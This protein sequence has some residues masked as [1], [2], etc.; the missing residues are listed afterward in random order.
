MGGGGIPVENLAP[1]MVLSESVYSEDGRLLL[2]KQG[3]TISEVLKRGLLKRGITRVTIGKN[4]PAAPA[5]PEANPGETAIPGTPF[6]FPKSLEDRLFITYNGQKVLKLD[7]PSIQ[8]TKKKALESSH[9]LLQGISAGNKVDREELFGTTASM[10]NAIVQNRDAFLNIAGIRAVDE[11]TFEHSVGVAAYTTI[12]AKEHGVPDEE[13]LTIC[14]GALLHDAGKM[15]VDPAILNKPGKLT[16]EEFR[17]MKTHTTK[18]YEILKENNI[19]EDLAAIALGHHERC[20]GKGYPKGLQTESV[21]MSAA[22]AAIADVYD[23]LTSDRVYRKAMDLYKAM[24]IIL[25][26]SGKQFNPKL[27]GVFQRVVGIYPIGSSVQLNDGCIARV[28]QQNEGVVRP[29]IQLFRDGRGSELEDKK[30]IDLMTDNDLY[31]VEA[32]T[33]SEAA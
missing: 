1:G 21:P 25:A 29:V 12:I 15:L 32:V 17:I 18:G 26:G 9:R 11:Y 30:V 14:S 4:S 7:D 2:I 20:D 16:D 3:V 24:S 23:A 5:G 6:S 27:V 22:M 33:E 31:I 8:Q 19:S 10:L 13:L 28:I